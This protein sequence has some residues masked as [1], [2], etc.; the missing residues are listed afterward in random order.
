M[1]G[2]AASFLN[3][4]LRYAVLASGARPVRCQVAWAGIIENRD[5]GSDAALVDVPTEL[6]TSVVSPGWD[7]AGAPGGASQ[8]PEPGA[9]SAGPGAA[10]RRRL[11]FKNG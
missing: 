11:D 3:D 7:G 4:R 8:R 2:T 5:D 9:G 6:F 10:Q 1:A